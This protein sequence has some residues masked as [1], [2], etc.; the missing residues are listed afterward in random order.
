MQ[1]LDVSSPRRQTRQALDRDVLVRAEQ[2]RA[3]YRNMPAAFIGSM[4][5]ASLVSA[6]LCDKL[7][8]WIILPW[9]AGTYA[10]CAVRFAVWRWFRISDPAPQQS[11][12][13]QRLA[14]GM[15]G[16]SG[17]MWGLGG[18]VLH[19]PGS[20]SQQLLLLVAV[21]GLGFISAYMTAPLMI[22][23]LAFVYP[24]YLLSVIPFMRDGDVLHIGIGVGTLLFLPV[25]IQVAARVCR[26]FLDSVNVRMKNAELLE[27]L[28][29]Q[30]EAAEEANIDKSR[31]LAAAS[32]DLRQ[33]L[34][35]LGL[36]VQALQESPIGAHERQI[37]ANIRRSVDAM[38]QLFDALL[39]ISRLDA[40]AVR[41]RVETFGLASMFDR[42][43]VEFGP[44]AQQK[45]LSLSVMRT[46]AC[47]S[48]DP[49]LLER[50]VRNLL[51]N[52]VSFTDRG[53]L[54]L[55]CRRQQDKLRIEVWDTGCGIPAEQHREI[56][57]EFAQLAAVERDQ[58]KGLGLGLAIV[59]RLARLLEHEVQVRSIPGKGSVFA[60]ALPRGRKED[61][62]AHTA[63][64][65]RTAFDLKGML[66]LVIDA[67]PAVRQAMETL[68][69]KWNCDVICAASG[70]EMKSKLVMAR[71]VPDLIISDYRLGI[72]VNP[73]AIHT[74]DVV[75]MLRSEFNTEIP[76]L[77]LTGDTVPNWGREWESG[78]LPVLYKPVNP[79][80]LRTLIAHLLRVDEN[81][82]LS[83][84][85][86]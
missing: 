72:A 32:H 58:R 29:E 67:E 56:F 66:I 31:F 68:L 16:A 52:A 79:A 8:L 43:R 83:R 62:T 45:G 70:A 27:K 17:L 48:S 76:A 64:E 37:V 50:I 2:I 5:V 69:S 71:R 1:T 28:R 65:F 10:L 82:E 26:T 41:P 80:R 61:F 78:A 75:E 38:E 6:M 77:L 51:T 59:Q 11:A 55:G 18:I 49:S 36:F 46:A 84:R 19:V 4:V 14:V 20:L 34:H 60:V 30:K 86:S 13:W 63:V 54:L 35:A 3:Q 22:A 73:G 42:L 7:S 25:V 57:R 21:T 74:A 15:A 81:E 33:P 44:V 85:V 47:V 12:R 23:F 24:S 40:G 53:G 9:L 39:D